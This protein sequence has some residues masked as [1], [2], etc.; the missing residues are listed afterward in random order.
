M[1]ICSVYSISIPG[2]IQSST[3]VPWFVLAVNPNAKPFGSDN[4]SRNSSLSAEGLWQKC[5]AISVE[6]GLHPSARALAELGAE[7]GPCEK[8]EN[9]LVKMWKMSS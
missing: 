5:L 9:Q 2:Y 7:L 1:Y 6:E 8:C 3:S 4:M